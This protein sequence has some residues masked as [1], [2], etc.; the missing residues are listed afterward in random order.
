MRARHLTSLILRAATGSALLAT[1]V[2]A[3]PAAEAAAILPPRPISTASGIAT[4]AA[5]STTAAAASPA[6][7]VGQALARK[8][9]GSSSPEAAYAAL[10]AAEKQALMA[11][12]TPVSQVVTLRPLVVS[13]TTALTSSPVV[14]I[15]GTT[16][17]CWYAELHVENNA[18]AGNTVYTYWQ[19]LRWCSTN[20]LTI[21]SWTVLDRGGETSTPGWSYEGHGISGG[22]LVGPQ[23]R[24]YTQEKFRFNV[25]WTNFV[26]S[27]CAQIR[28]G[29][30][31]AASSLTTC[32]V[33]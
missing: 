6:L 5:T 3:A 16:V 23:V 32:S 25:L 2:V 21:S 12:E 14:G 30:R 28:G 15:A 8:V 4:G 33:A 10:G 29:A 27:P 13:G 20:G 18:V 7:A 1:L 24:S 11:F 19:R 26:N 17:R 22:V 31:G 9:F